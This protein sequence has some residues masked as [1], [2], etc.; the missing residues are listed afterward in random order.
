V[1]PE[2]DPATVINPKAVAY[3]L[4]AAIADRPQQKAYAEKRFR[5]ALATA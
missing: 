3:K 4:L 1:T 2:I 5:E